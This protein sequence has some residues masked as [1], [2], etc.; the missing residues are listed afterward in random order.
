M[1][2]IKKYL[3]IGT[4]SLFPLLSYSQKPNTAI[5]SVLINPFEG[6]KDFASIIVYNQNKKVI[7]TIQTN[8]TG[9]GNY[10]LP[11]KDT[12]TYFV[13]IEPGKGD[14]GEEGEKFIPYTSSFKIKPGKNPLKILKR[15]N[16]EKQLAKKD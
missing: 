4:I 8:F 7:D 5:G 6:A 11:A 3:T 16:L 10:N 1:N 14:F 13:K 12:T 9:R 2:K 15:N